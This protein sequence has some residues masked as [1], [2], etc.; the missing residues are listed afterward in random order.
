MP[1]FN[2]FLMVDSASLALILLKKE[3][4]APAPL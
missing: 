4:A 1:V 3:I 2:P